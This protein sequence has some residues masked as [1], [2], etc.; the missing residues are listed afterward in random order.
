MTLFHS[1]A[2]EISQVYGRH[3]CC[4]SHINIW[5]KSVVLLGLCLSPVAIQV[6]VLGGKYEAKY[7]NLIF[8]L[9]YFGF[10][11]VPLAICP[12]L[13]L[14]I[15]TYGWRGALQVHKS[16]SV[17]NVKETLLASVTIITSVCVSRRRKSA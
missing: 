14:L 2:K 17:E 15:D 16:T 1:T 4:E 12:L 5:P 10:G 6:I 9:G 13:Q 8:Q 11:S 7:S 3:G